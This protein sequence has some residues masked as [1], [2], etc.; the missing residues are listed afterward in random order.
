MKALPGHRKIGRVSRKESLLEK[1][2]IP[3]DGSPTDAVTHSRPSSNVPTNANV[4][5]SSR[6]G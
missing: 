6:G 2:I 4:Q 5:T 1:T 3:K